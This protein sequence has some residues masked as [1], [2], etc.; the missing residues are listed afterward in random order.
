MYEAT[1]LDQVVD[2]FSNLEANFGIAFGTNDNHIG[3]FGT[4][5]MPIRAN[6]TKGSFI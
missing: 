2:S 1:H 6:P 5:I 3:F 4:G